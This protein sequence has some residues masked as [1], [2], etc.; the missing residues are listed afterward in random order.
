M[1]E[2]HSADFALFAQAGEVRPET[3]RTVL[4]RFGSQRAGPSREAGPRTG[5]VE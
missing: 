1:I 3:A 2:E 4:A 5:D